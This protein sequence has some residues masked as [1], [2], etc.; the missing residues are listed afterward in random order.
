MPAKTLKTLLAVALAVT[1]LAANA[2]LADRKSD[3]PAKP[4]VSCP[5]QSTCDLSEVSGH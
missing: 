5:Q 3:D 2:S 1:A 4:I